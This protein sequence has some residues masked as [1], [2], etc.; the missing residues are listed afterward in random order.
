M[1]YYCQQLVF[2]HFKTFVSSKLLKVHIE[3]S[4]IRLKMSDD[5]KGKQYTAW[6]SQFGYLYSV[7]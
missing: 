6:D 3:Y 2:R 5:P 4:H 7:H 1:Q